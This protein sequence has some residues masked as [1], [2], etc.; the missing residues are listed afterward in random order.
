MTR[1]I[2]TPV[3]AFADVQETAVEVKHRFMT[4]LNPNMNYVFDYQPATDSFIGGVLGG[5]ICH[6]LLYVQRDINKPVVA[7]LSIDDR[8]EILTELSQEEFYSFVRDQAVRAHKQRQLE[9]RS[10]GNIMR[11]NWLKDLI[12]LGQCVVKS[13][14]ATHY[15]HV[16]RELEAKP[17]MYNIEDV[18]TKSRGILICQSSTFYSKGERKT[19][20]SYIL[21]KANGICDVFEGNVINFRSPSRQFFVE[22]KISNK[23]RK[24]VVANFDSLHRVV[25]R[26]LINEDKDI[27]RFVVMSHGNDMCAYMEYDTR[28]NCYYGDVK[29]VNGYTGIPTPRLCFDL[30]NNEISLIANYGGVGVKTVYK[31]TWLIESELTRV[32]KDNAD[33]NVKPFSLALINT[34]LNGMDVVQKG[35]HNTTTWSKVVETDNESAHHLTNKG[36]L[37]KKVVSYFSSGVQ[38]HEVEY[39]VLKASGQM[40]HYVGNRPDFEMRGNLVSVEWKHN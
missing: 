9:L 5:S 39:Y 40:E 12:R 34:V 36:R 21:V 30:N 20:T 7:K 33:K 31:D 1:T 4:A 25:S 23:E 14:N 6:P 17:N 13:A 16:V 11:L 35:K 26:F 29:R 18:T 19:K 24:A 37:I 15:Y 2:K 3:V 38:K 27:L 10:T 22:V 28:D 8:I 32:Y